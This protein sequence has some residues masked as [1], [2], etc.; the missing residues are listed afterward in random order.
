MIG[1]EGKRKAVHIG[2]VAFALYGIAFVGGWIEQ[3][4]TITRAASAQY[5]G[6]AI[7]LV[8]PAD[9]MWRR[10]AHELQP[11]V[12]RDFQF[13]PFSSASLPSAAMIVW[14][15]GYVLV[16]LLLAFNLFR[17]RAL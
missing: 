8:S 10:A 12:L 11:P 4:G 1:S 15:V 14:T 17:R 16:V 9:A 6:T 5:I 3:I 2:M 7:S 13:S